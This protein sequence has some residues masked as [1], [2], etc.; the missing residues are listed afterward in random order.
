LFKARRINEICQNYGVPL[1][2]AALQFVLAHPAVASVLSG[3]RSPQEIE[4]NFELIQYPIPKEMW[5][6][7]KEQ[8]LI[9]PSA[10][11]SE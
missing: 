1:K 7:L 5:G 6:S 3:A 9:D 4:E 8:E 2:A 11:L 10:P